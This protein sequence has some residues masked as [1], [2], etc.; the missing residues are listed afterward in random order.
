MAPDIETEKFI[1]LEKTA[2]EIG[3]SKATLL[4]YIKAG[5]PV[6]DTFKGL[7]KIHLFLLSEVKAWIREKRS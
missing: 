1:S 5:C 6:H 4:N 2:E 3:V 7:K